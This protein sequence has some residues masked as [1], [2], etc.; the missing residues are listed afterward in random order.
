LSVPGDKSL[1]HRAAL[2]GAMAVGETRV[3]GFLTSEDCLNTLRALERMGVTVTRNG[4]SV[5]VQ[6]CGGR[7]RAPDGVLDMGNSGTGIR[8]ICGLLAGQPFEVELTGDASLRSRPMGRIKEPLERMGARLELTGPKGTAPIRIRGNALRGIAYPSPVASAQ[9]KSCVLLAGLLAEGATSVTEPKPT[10]DHTERM[11]HAMGAP[12]R[13]EGL[14]VTL[15]LGLRGGLALKPL[16]GRIP[17]DFSSAAFWLVAGA[18]ATG[19]ESVVEEVGLNPRRTALLDVLGRMGAKVSV[20]PVAGSEE[21]EPRGTVTVRGGAL[22]GTAV[23][24][25]EIPNLIDELPIVA[26]AGALAGG[27]TEIRDAAELRVKESDRIACMATNLRKM[28]VTVEERPD[29]MTVIGGSPIRGGAELESYGD[30]RIAMAMAVLGLYAD[31]PITIRDVDCVATS[32]PGFREHL[33]LFG[34]GGAAA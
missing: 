9:V 23:E 12:L 31:A 34:G 29:G 5:T 24:G 28:G 20:Q 16:R 3:T 13:A 10:R 17:G 15:P 25:E 21:W 19:A 4:A 33:A 32:Y 27:R 7:L 30:H 18:A 26:V 22:R 2:L 1:S 6:G 8:L 14:T 11:L